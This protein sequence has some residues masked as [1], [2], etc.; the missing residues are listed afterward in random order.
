MCPIA[1]F[2]YTSAP[3]PVLIKPNCGFIPATFT[4]PVKIFWQKEHHPNAAKLEN[5]MFFVKALPLSN[6]MNIDE[7]N[8]QL[9][10]VFNTYNVNILFCTH[11]LPC[12]VNNNNFDPQQMA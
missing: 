4:Q 12:K 8:Q 6:K 3:I 1:Y 10:R 2:V 9:A 7:M 11:H 5:C